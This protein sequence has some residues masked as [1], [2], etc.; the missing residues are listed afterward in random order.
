MVHEMNRQY[1][2]VWEIILLVSSC[3]LSAQDI[4]NLRPLDNNQAL[5]ADTSD[6]KPH[7][8]IKNMQLSAKNPDINLSLGGEIRE[9]VRYYNRMNYG[10]VDSGTPNTDLFLMQRYMLHANLQLGKHIRFFSQLVSGM[11]N[12]KNTI[13]Q[14]DKDVLGVLQAFADLNFSAPFPMQFRLGRQELSFGAD[15]MLGVRDG[16]VLRQSYDGLRYTLS[17]KKITGDLFVVYPVQYDF[18]SFDNSTNTGNLI[19]SAYWTMPLSRN[20]MLDLYYFGNNRKD[21][22]I[23]NDIADEDRH[24][25]GLRLSRSKGPFLYDAEAVWQTGFYDN[26]AIRAWQLL[27]TVGYRW[28]DTR[29]KPRLGVRIFAASGDRDSTDGQLNLFRPV[30]ARS[31]L[32]DLVPMGA[33]N[34]ALLSLEGDIMLTR[35]TQFNL[36]YYTLRR[37]SGNDGLYASDMAFMTREPDR[38]GVEN[39]L[40]IAT[41][42]VTE[43]IHKAGKHFEIILYGGY[44]RPG[45]YLKNTGQGMNM[46]IMALKA[47][48]RF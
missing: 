27:G 33:A 38:N 1:T 37:V 15:R 44:F 46:G 20:T 4:D 31:P 36:R 41:G 5:R 45:E 16:R 35:K 13:L 34:V 9:Q 48:Y 21:V 2:L 23:G 28:Q 6:W 19:Y 30:S 12:G 22:L 24:S 10:D 40:K 11:V 29:L 26:L 39:G 47:T 32:H 7:R 8:V 17:L 18:G 25:F 3:A 42:I 43:I 14:V